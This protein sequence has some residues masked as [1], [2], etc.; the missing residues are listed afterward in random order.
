MRLVDA[1]VFLEVELGQE[2]SAECEAYLGRLRDG[3]ETAVLSQV[4]V[5][6]I[7][8]VMER[9]NRSWREIRRFLLSLSLFRGLRIYTPT[10][11]DR[12]HATRLMARYGLDFEDSLVL[13]AMAAN[14][15]PEIV[16]LDKD[17]DR[18]REIKRL[19]PAEALASKTS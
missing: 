3:E 16:S 9:Y 6:S 7:A 11:L 10:L 18:V 2:H 14:R 13:Q 15:I 5:D 1:N 19:T 8:L 17:F 4:A 12:V